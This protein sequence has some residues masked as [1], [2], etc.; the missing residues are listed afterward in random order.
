MPK[1]VH[2][3]IIV[4]LLTLCYRSKLTLAQD[5][6][7][8]EQS[9]LCLQ[10]HSQTYYTFHNTL[11]GTNVH[12]R[13]NPYLKID[14][15]QYAGA[16]HHFFS[17]DDCHS[18]EYATYPHKAELKLEVL[19][20]C[21]DC[22]GGDESFAKYQ[23]DNIAGEVDQSVHRTAF[24][25]QF[26][27]E[28]CHNLHTYKLSAR[29]T[30]NSITSIVQQN[31]LMCLN[32]HQNGSLYNA[33]SSNTAPILENTHSWL[34]NQALHFQKVRC[35]ECHTPTTDTMMVSHNIR[36]KAEAVR[37]CAECHSTHSILESKLY[38]YAAKSARSENGYY[39]AILL[40]ESY[41]IG[42]NR[43]RYFN[44]FTFIAIGLTLLGIIIHLTA[45]ILNKK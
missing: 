20:S 33:Y 21:L 3:I 26:K 14:S 27:C 2:Y 45:R 19:P 6:P 42:A 17:C 4:C 30:L 22:H 23:F 12:K 25:D 32:C 1:F 13:M 28:S 24:G 31:N 38:K 40:N 8:S 15:T 39:N 10:C 16:L 37:K 7:L 36:P 44:L 41:V 34:P 43:N 11:T 35:I 9:R 29:D 5:D 18:Y